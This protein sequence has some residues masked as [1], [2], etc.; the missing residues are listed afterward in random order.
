MMKMSNIIILGGSTIEL[1]DTKIA[2]NLSDVENYLKRFL[3]DGYEGLMVR[4]LDRPY[5]HKRSDQ[6]LKMK[7]F[8]E[9]EFLI[10]GVEEG[11]GKLQGHGIFVCVTNEFIEFRV[12]MS[13]PTAKLKEYWENKKEYIGHNLTV[14][15]QGR[16]SDGV[17]RFPVGI[18][19]REDL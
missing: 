6:L 5:E 10:T 1:V 16:T 13:G 17:P 8:E 15:Y 18:R 14:Q 2:E 12:K 3:E 19:I 7:K 9:S 11:R 4:S